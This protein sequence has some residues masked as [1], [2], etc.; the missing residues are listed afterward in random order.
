[1]I[2]VVPPD[3]LTVDLGPGTIS[4]AAWSGAYPGGAAGQIARAAAAHDAA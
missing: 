4:G 2:S 3:A 1:M